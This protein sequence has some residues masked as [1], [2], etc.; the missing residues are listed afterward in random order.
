[1]NLGFYRGKVNIDISHKKADTHG[2]MSEGT[3]SFARFLS[4]WRNRCLPEQFWLGGRL[5]ARGQQLALVGNHCELHLPM[6]VLQANSL[7]A[8]DICRVLL[9]RANIKLANEN[10]DALSFHSDTFMQIELLKRA[11]R[12]FT[13][14]P[15]LAVMAERWSFFLQKVRE[16][17]TQMDFLEVQTPSLVQ[18]PGMEPE[19]EPFAVHW[20]Q[21]SVTKKLFLPTSPE[22][23]IKQLMVQGLSDVFEIK[24]VFRNEEMTDMH[25]PEFT[26]LEWYRGFANLEM[27]KADVRGLVQFLAQ[28]F[29]TQIPVN[30]DIPEFKCAHFFQEI[31]DFQLSPQTTKEELLTLAQKLGLSPDSAWDWNDLYHLIWV[32]KIEPKLPQ[33]LF[34]LT[35]YPA[36]QAALAKVSADGWAERTELYWDGV[37]L[38]NAFHELTDPHEQRSRFVRDQKK[39]LEYGRTPL[40]IDENFM[41]AL[42]MGLPPSAGIALG[43]DRLFMKM[44]GAKRIQDT[45]AFGIQHQI[46]KEK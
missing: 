17:F 25:E 45:R 41:T 6:S 14:R 34:F 42:E 38:A 13:E 15:G 46:I 26:M 39:R 33:G 2:R 30:H 5:L 28:H 31:L 12:P 37:E 7:M 24:N 23:H 29:P 22:L 19:L 44:T 36:S 1:M 11:E 10:Q 3:Y 4:A 16:Y 18:N 9:H 20:R 40:T 21:G 35:A 32:A 27:I 43:L 8:G